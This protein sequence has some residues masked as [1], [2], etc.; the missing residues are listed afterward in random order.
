MKHDAFLSHFFA[1]T[2]SLGLALFGLLLLMSLA[3]WYFILAKAYQ[4]QLTRRRS[5]RFEQQFWNAA[6]LDGV[7]EH[8]AQAPLADPFSRLAWQSL[9]ARRQHG[10]IQTERLDT[11]GSMADVLSRRMQQ[12]IDVETTQLEN[13]LTLLASVAAV[14]P[15][16]GLFG[17]VWGVYHAL[18]AIGSE[19]AAGLEQIAGPVGEALIMTAFGLAVA[20]PALLAYNA[21]TRGNRVL[22]ARLDRFAHD[23][24][25]FITTGQ[26]AKE[27]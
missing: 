12:A 20:I 6:S 8:L 18:S 2:D 25:H 15:F 17:T 14:A 5:R 9:L 13:G 1:Q 19:G 7:A 27:R 21:F 10:Q 4:W 22:L 24:F 26:S 11:A 23:L 16:V 3:S